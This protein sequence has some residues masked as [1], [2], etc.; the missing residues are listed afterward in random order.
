[1]TDDELR[2]LIGAM[3]NVGTDLRQVE[4][5]RASTQLPR[6]LWESL[7]A[8]AN[9]PGGGI[10]ILGVDETRGFEVNGVSDA[11]KI[12]QDLASM[13]AEMEP[14]LTPIINIHAFDGRQVIVAEVTEL[15]PTEKPCYHRAGGYTNGAFI[16]IADG[17]HKLTTYEV[18]MMLS[19]RGQPAEDITPMVTA[20]RSDFDETLVASFVTRVRERRVRFRSKTD[21]QILLG[22]KALVPHPD[23]HSPPVPSIAGLLAFGREPQADL[24]EFAVVVTAFPG[25]RIGEL[26]PSGERILDDARI[27]GPVVHMVREAIGVILRNLRQARRDAGA[28]RTVVD[29]LPR[30]VLSEAL[31][32]ALAHRDLSPLSRGTPVQVQIFTD[33]VVIKNPGGLF[34]QVS[35][36]TIGLNS[37]S[38]ARN[39]VLMQLLEDFIMPGT[40]DAIAEHR[41]TGIAAMMERLR[42]ADL[43][44]AQFENTVGEFT[45]V[46]PRGPLMSLDTMAWLASLGSHAEGLSTTQRIA[47]ALMRNGE[48]LTNLRYRQVNGSDNRVATR[49][50]SNLVSRGLAQM[51]GT[52][53][54][55][56]YSLP[57]I[58]RGRTTGVAER[59]NTVGYTVTVRAPRQQRADRRPAIREL[60]RARGLMSRAEIGYALGLT[61]G[62]VSRWLRKMIETREVML[63]VAEAHDPKA[64]YRLSG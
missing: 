34:G 45:L 4:A 61:Q 51:L 26:G 6:R 41:G 52:G 14:R 21:D 29:E 37:T 53:R 10:L 42:E 64:R 9:S 11:K 13:C 2:E 27:E 59:R 28:F 36:D 8:F 58:P 5:K 3:R 30:V 7:S 47:L 57:P 1:M 38:S 40:G 48:T 22:L 39:P 15:L 49:E 24:P 62:P 32:N 17:D 44:P 60:L 12:F 23:A 19:A 56:T 55:A 25:R 31:V 50:L 33:R 35:A 18:Q 20:Q 43:S 63:T 16:R 54:F 46:L